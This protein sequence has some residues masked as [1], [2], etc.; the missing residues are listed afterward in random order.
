MSK[1]WALASG[2]LAFCLLVAGTGLLR[3]QERVQ[4]ERTE[5]RSSSEVRRISTVIGSSVVLEAGGDFGKVEDFVLNEDGCIDY[6]VVSY[7]DRYYVMPWT[8]A[9]VDFGRRTVRVDITRERLRDAPTFTGRNWSEITSDRFT[10]RVR[11]FYRSGGERRGGVGVERRGRDRGVDVERRDREF[12]RDRRGRDFDRDRRDRDFDRGD[13]RDRDFDRDRRGRDFDRERRDRDFDRDRRD[14]GRPLPPDRAPRRGT[15]ERPGTN[16]RPPDRSRGEQPED[17]GTTP[18]RRPG[19]TNPP[20]PGE[21][22]R[23]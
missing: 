6:M 2:G 10:Q 22:G 14:S 9:T 3:S 5:T 4:T 13:R 19:G 7:E 8:V 18:S 23:P 1:V 12:D 17:R 11:S 16:P 20:R 15:D 21:P